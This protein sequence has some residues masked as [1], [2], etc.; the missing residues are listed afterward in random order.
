MLSRERLIRSAYLVYYRQALAEYF[1][2]KGKAKDT[3]EASSQ[4]ESMEAEDAEVGEIEL[5]E[6]IIM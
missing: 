5:V 4:I 3:A 1:V 6:E 2:A